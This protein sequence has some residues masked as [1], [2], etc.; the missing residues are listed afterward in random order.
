MSTLKD[1]DERKKR[2]SQSDFSVS[3]RGKQIARDYLHAWRVKNV[4]EIMNMKNLEVETLE[5]CTR[6]LSQEDSDGILGKWGPENYYSLLAR[7]EYG[8]PVTPD[9]VIDE[10]RNSGECRCEASRLTTDKRTKEQAIELL[11]SEFKKNFFAQY[12]A[13]CSLH[14]IK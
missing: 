9:E 4:F 10:F 12:N 11:V 6:R 2:E 3:D 5:R 8:R 13:Y 1:V 7:V 14:K